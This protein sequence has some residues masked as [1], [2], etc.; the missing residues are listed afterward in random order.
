MD[1]YWIKDKQRCGP[2]TVPDVISQLQVGE[3]TPETLGWHAGCPKW[4][5]LR[6]LPALADFLNKDAA[7]QEPEGDAPA[8]PPAEESEASAELPATPAAA[9]DEADEGSRRVYLPRPVARLLARLVDCALYAV[10]YGAVISLRGIPYDASLLLSVNPLLWLPLMVLEAWMLSTWGTTPGKALMGIRITTFGDVPRLSFLR[11][12]MRSCMV[13]CFGM[14][15]MIPYL[16]PIMLAFEY[17]MLRQRGIT[18]WDARNSTLPTQKHAATP[19]RYLLAVILLYV[20]MVLFFACMKPWLPGMLQDI[21][22]TDPEMA[23]KLS[24]FMPDIMP[25]ATLPP[26]AP[27]ATAEPAAAPALHGN[28][29]P[30]I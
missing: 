6:E 17:W 19:S 20:S 24:Q 3:L 4:L 18:P 29:L 30:G 21:A 12:L 9:K 16:M 8:A 7:A 14:G 26:A 5:P 11:A 10:L 2:S 23:D 13:F 25:D 28:S 22:S 27:P 15:L 1:I